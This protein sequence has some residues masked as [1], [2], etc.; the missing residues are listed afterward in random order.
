MQTR[1][2]SF[3]RVLHRPTASFF[4][5]LAILFNNAS[6]IDAGRRLLQ[7]TPPITVRASA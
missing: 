4:H 3:P 6:L 2:G 5:A 1:T 7:H